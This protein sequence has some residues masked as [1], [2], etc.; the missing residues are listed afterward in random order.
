M[1]QITEQ[2]CDKSKVVFIVMKT[3]HMVNRRRLP[4]AVRDSDSSRKTIKTVEN[5][6]TDGDSLISGL[7]FRK[8]EPLFTSI[9]TQSHFTITE[10]S[11]NT[12]TFKDGPTQLYQQAF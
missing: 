4:I 8:G 10:R 5:Q 1:P 6:V 7:G 9:G 2:V 12:G 3:T 11:H